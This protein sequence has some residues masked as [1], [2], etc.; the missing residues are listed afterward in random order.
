[1]QCNDTAGR[2]VLLH[3]AQGRLLPAQAVSAGGVA[4]RERLLAARLGC[5][6]CGVGSDRVYKL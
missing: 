6:G 3:Q 2:A 4:Q 1:M 5:G